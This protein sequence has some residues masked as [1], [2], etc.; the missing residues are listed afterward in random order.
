MTD[1]HCDV[2]NCGN[3]KQNFCCRPDIMV[4]GPRASASTQTY[5][6][7]FIDAKEGG[8][9]PQN[10]IDHESPNPSLD[11]HC[12]VTKCTYNQQRA[13]SADHID[14]RTTE[15]NNGQVKTECAT[16]E[17]RSGGGSSSGGGGKGS[18]D[19]GNGDSSG[20]GGSVGGP[21]SGNQN[22]DDSGVCFGRNP[23]RL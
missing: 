14:I 11:V 5:C 6:A 4:G 3:N 19:W 8:G 7:N 21:S 9:T 18:S 2:T 17:N 22:G 20:R 10:A 16:F 13:C 12:E 15:V 23:N 1:L